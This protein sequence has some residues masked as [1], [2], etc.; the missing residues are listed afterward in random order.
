MHKATL[1]EELWASKE[2]TQEMEAQ[3]KKKDEMLATERA[4]ISKLVIKMVD[5]DSRRIVVEDQLKTIKLKAKAIEVDA[6]AIVEQELRHTRGPRTSK[7]KW[8]RAV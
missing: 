6:Q 1:K 4:W 3:I 2:L 8:L 7:M 5:G